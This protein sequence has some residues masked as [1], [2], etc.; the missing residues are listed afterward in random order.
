MPSEEPYRMV[1]LGRSTHGFWPAAARCTGG[2]KLS[3]WQKAKRMG[4]YL[5]RV[6]RYATVFR[7]QRA[8]KVLT[9]GADASHSACPRTRKSTTGVVCRKG[10]HL[11]SALS[12]TQGV[13]R[14]SSG[15]AEYAEKTVIDAKGAAPGAQ[16]DATIDRPN[17]ALTA[18][19][20]DNMLGTVNCP[21][22]DSALVIG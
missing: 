22:V 7:W 8:T 17:Y 13:V 15:E 10:H 5:K 9:I 21:H 6:P 1:L 3:S 12:A 16:F 14:L 19:P 11:L 2:P 4:R 18:L 20:A